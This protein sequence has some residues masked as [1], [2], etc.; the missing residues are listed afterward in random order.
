MKSKARKMEL[1]YLL[2]F[3]SIILAVRCELMWPSGTYGIP[4]AVTGCPDFSGTSWKRGY[5]YHDTAD[6]EPANKRSANY[7]LAGNF[8]QHGIEQRFCIKD[9]PEGGSEFWPEGK[10]CIYKKGVCPTN[11]DE[12]SIKWDDEHSKLDQRNRHVGVLPDGNYEETSTEV[13]YCCS[14]KGDVTKPINLPNTAPF[15]LMTYDSPTC[16]KV[17]GMKASSEFIKFDDNDKGNTN[18]AVGAHPYGPS[19]DKFNTKVYYCYYEPGEEST[20]DLGTGKSIQ[21][22]KEHA[23]KSSS[24]LAVAIGCGVAG[25]IVGTASIVFTT[26]RIL[27][28]RAKGL[29]DGMEG[30]KPDAP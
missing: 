8:T 21:D 24:G 12:G 22:D 23:P 17:A 20:D 2:F 13:K 9:K 11:M 1:K 4:E 19:E 3:S 26:R 25:A 15:Y 10:Y 7:H 6:I 14:T 18:A 16:Q 28:A 30:P 5:T 27:A 29:A